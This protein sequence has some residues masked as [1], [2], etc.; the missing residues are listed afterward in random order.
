MRNLGESRGISVL[1]TTTTEVFM[2]CNGGPTGGPTTND[3][4]LEALEALLCS[5][6]HSLERLEYD[7][8]ET[9]K[10][11]EFWEKHK[12]ADSARELREAKRRWEEKK[13]AQLVEK[14]W[15]SLSPQERR[16]VEKYF[17]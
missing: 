5:A 2:P 17:E 14:P 12:Q 10:L 6:C 7:F 1:Q 9:P 13:A 8:R 15:A 11:D 3:S 4:H 16:L